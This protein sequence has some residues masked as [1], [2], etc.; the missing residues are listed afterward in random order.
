MGLL[1]LFAGD[2][3]MQVFFDTQGM[4]LN[5]LFTYSYSIVF[6]LVIANV[7]VFLIESGYQMEVNKMEERKKEEEE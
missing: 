7:F 3:L 1:A 5:N 4:P 6:L 2:E